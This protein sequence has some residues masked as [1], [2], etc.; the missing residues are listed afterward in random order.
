MALSGPRRAPQTG[1]A[2]E[3]VVLVHGYGADGDDLIGLAAPLAEHLP[4]AAFVAPHAPYP[5]PGA[6]FM[7]FPITD[8]DPRAMH[9]GVSA[10]APLLH[11]FIEEELQRYGLAA[12]RLALIGFSQGTMLSLHLA[13]GALKPAAVLGFSGVLTGGAAPN[14]NLPPIFLAHGSDD[15]VIPVDAL[16]MTAAALAAS[17][18]RVQWHITPQMGHGIGDDGLALAGGFLKLAFAGILAAQGPASSPLR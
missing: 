16:F 5:C 13:L 14:R 6:R 17:G 8:L 1:K 9:Q 7:W 10:A 3:L 11:A 2:S 18:G 15:P 12:D 4:G